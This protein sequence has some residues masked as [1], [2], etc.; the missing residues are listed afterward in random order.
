MNKKYTSYII[1]FVLCLNLVPQ[2]S[3]AFK[4]NEQKNDVIYDTENEK[5]AWQ[6]FYLPYAKH[7]KLVPK[8]TTVL[9]LAKKTKEDNDNIDLISEIKTRTNHDGA[10]VI[11]KWEKDNGYIDTKAEKDFGITLPIRKKL[12]TEIEE[13]EEKEKKETNQFRWK[14]GKS[15]LKFISFGATLA[16]SRWL[17]KDWDK[18][19]KYATFAVV[20]ASTLA[21]VIEAGGG[22]IWSNTIGRLWKSKDDKTKLLPLGKLPKLPENYQKIDIYSL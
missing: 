3:L 10:K 8:T 19:G 12:L 1:I 17:A 2:T 6:T 14:T 13:E 15:D 11:V 21:D 16:I 18:A 5:R 4:L 20:G 22:W 9:D 7:L